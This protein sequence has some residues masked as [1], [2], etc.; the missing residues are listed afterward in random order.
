[1]IKNG[2][3]EGRICH[4]YVMVVMIGH[5]NY[6]KSWVVLDILLVCHV[7]KWVCHDV[8]WVCHVIL[9]V[10]HDILCIMI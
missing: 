9:C 3:E 4:E 1:M 5:D 8:L 2:H 6:H 10:C 7:I